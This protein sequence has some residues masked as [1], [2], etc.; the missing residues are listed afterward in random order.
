MHFRDMLGQML[1]ENDGVLNDNQLQEFSTE[2]RINRTAIPMLYRYTPA[3]YYNIR[4]LETEKLALSKAGHMNDV[5]EGLANSV[6]EKLIEQ[7]A[8][9]EDI[10]YMKSFSEKENDLHMWSIYASECEGM[11][12]EY[13]LREME[14]KRDYY[15]YLFPI[16]YIKRRYG[17]SKVFS[18]ARVDW[19]EAYKYGDDEAKM[20]N[21]ELLCDVLSPFLS[22]AE[23]W[24]DEK[25]WRVIA[26][27]IRMHIEEELGCRFEDEKHEENYNI[28]SEVID[29]PY[30]TCVF[31][32]PRMEKMKKE[33][34]KEIALKKLK[35]R[36]VET[37]IAP[38][39][40]NLEK[41]E[42]WKDGEEEWHA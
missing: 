19:F 16:H 41:R 6:D 2:L 8:K 9:I 30:A 3:D 25:E 24:Q 32:G 1:D 21:A 13:D 14:G 29:F 39:G 42:I 23:C 4:N 40:Y 12:V 27:Y 11:C 33:H 26:S 36:V 20:N 34:L 17:E 38:T 15:S 31:L 18:K 28:K 7:F 22:K 37:R 5:F 10:A 35:I